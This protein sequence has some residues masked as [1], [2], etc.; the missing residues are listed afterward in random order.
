MVMKMMM[1]F[2]RLEAE[3]IAL[4][5]DSL[6]WPVLLQVTAN[7][8]FRVILFVFVF[9]L[10]W[11]FVCDILC[12]CGLFV[13][14]LFSLF[15]CSPFFPSK[16]EIGRGV[17][18]WQKLSGF[19]NRKECKYPTWGF[20]RQHPLKVEIHFFKTQLQ[21]VPPI[22]SRQGPLRWE[23]STVGTVGKLVVTKSWLMKTLK[24]VNW[25]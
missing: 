9:C 1:I 16:V 20:K 25:V 21:S 4:Q 6:S 2:R 11:F 5:I 10:F 18:V 22:L 12:V 7:F 8:F 13:L 23:L 19:S 14:I 3:F 17:S 24:T 15:F